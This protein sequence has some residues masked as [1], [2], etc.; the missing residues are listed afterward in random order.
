MDLVAFTPTFMLLFVGSLVK[1]CLY[2]VA[3][4]HTLSTRQADT[5]TGRNVSSS[6]FFLV[7]KH[8]SIAPGQNLAVIKRCKQAILG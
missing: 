2:S 5:N 3:T 8:R 4:S 6:L 7:L 1:A